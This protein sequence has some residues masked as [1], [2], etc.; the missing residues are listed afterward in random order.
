MFLTHEHLHIFYKH[1][2]K[3][4]RVKYLERRVFISYGY[5]SFIN[6]FFLTFQTGASIQ[7][8]RI[9]YRFDRGGFKNDIKNNI[10]IIIPKETLV[11]FE[12]HIS[13]IVQTS[14]EL[15][16]D[17]EF[18]LH[19]ELLNFFDYLMIYTDIISSQLVG[20]TF[21]DLLRTITKTG[22]FNRTT[23]KIFTNPYYIPI[24]KSYINNINIQVYYPTG[25]LARFENN[26]SKVL[27]TLHFRPLKNA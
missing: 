20:D 8:K 15:N 1:K 21:A 14:K 26:L 17:Y 7:K 19:S 3:E 6:M 18:I 9:R 10:A 24:N 12:G 11:Q 22:E 23:E 13:T 4:K 2:N 27:V 5:I 16:T 25:D